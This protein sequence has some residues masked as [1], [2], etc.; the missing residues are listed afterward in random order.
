MGPQLRE[1]ADGLL[2]LHSQRV[3][4]GDLRGVSLQQLN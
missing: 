2:Y 1:I 4:H 3:A